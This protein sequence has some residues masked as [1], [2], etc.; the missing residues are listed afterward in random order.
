MS[1]DDGTA[2]SVLTGNSA[3]TP[4]A[5]KRARIMSSLGTVTRTRSVYVVDKSKRDAVEGTALIE[6]EEI[7]A[8]RDPDDLRDLIQERAEEPA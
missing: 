7:D 3:F 5:E 2:E 1:E 6:R 4:T 8:I